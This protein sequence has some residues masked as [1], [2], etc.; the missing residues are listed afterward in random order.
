MTKTYKIVRFE[1]GKYA[2][3]I[4]SD[5][6]LKQAKNWHNDKPK[7]GDGWSEGWALSEHDFSDIFGIPVEVIC[8]RIMATARD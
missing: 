5:L 8:S 3:T 1:A 7:R 4:A 2:Q 6:T